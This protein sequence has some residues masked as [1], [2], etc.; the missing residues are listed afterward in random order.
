MLR[1]IGKRLLL[2]IPTLFGLSVLLA[3]TFVASEA[4]ARW[5][6]LPG[7]GGRPL[8]LCAPAGGWDELHRAV[9]GAGF[10][11]SEPATE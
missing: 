3:R 8:L 11:A 5:E 4:G 7:V 10:T 2:L 9:V 6:L 1:T